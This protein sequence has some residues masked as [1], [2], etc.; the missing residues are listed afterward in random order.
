MITWFSQKNK[1]VLPFRNP[2]LSRTEPVFIRNTTIFSA[3]VLKTRVFQEKLGYVSS[4][5]HNLPSTGC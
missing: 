1:L 4:I 5:L 3:L 2:Y